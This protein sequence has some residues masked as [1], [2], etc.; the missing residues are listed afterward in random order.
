MDSLHI[1]LIYFFELAFTKLDPEKIYCSLLEEY[2]CDQDAIT[3][4][5]DTMKV[6]VNT[7]IWKHSLAKKDSQKQSENDN[8]DAVIIMKLYM[9]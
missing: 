3:T 8:Q 2:T 7:Y 6:Y 9:H 4:F 5:W 1:K